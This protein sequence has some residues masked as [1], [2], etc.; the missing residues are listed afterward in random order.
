MLNVTRRPRVINQVTCQTCDRMLSDAPDATYWLPVTNCFCILH[1]FALTKT[2]MQL[3]HQPAMLLYLWGKSLWEA[4]HTELTWPVVVC[5]LVTAAAALHNPSSPPKSQ[6]ATGLGSQQY[7]ECLTL[8]Q[9][10]PV[11]VYALFPVRCSVWPS[12]AEQH[13]HWSSVKLVPLPEISSP[14]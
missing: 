6:P 13:P 2:P 14:F 12:P 4:N 9:P 8:G 1:I 10:P 3:K 5:T 7:R 11:A